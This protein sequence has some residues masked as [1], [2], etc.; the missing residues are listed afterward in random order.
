MISNS[1]GKSKEH[2]AEYTNSPK[3]DSGQMYRAKDGQNVIKGN[4]EKVF[5][6]NIL[7]RFDTLENIKQ[8]TY[9]VNGS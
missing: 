8:G 5:E 7:K 2:I 1:S 4:L 6:F 9:A 3:S